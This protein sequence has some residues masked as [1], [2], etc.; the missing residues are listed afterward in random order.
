MASR[1]PGSRRRKPVAAL[2]ASIADATLALRRKRSRDRRRGWRRA[3]VTALGVLVVAAL[4]WTIGFSPWLAAKDV[5]VEGNRVLTVA[6]VEGRAAVP[7]GTPLARLRTAEIADRVATLPAVADVEVHRSWPGRVVVRVSERTPVVQ[8]QEG[9]AFRWAD[10]EGVVFHQTNKA[11]PGLVTVQA[12]ADQRILA[13][14]ATVTSSLTDP[15]RARVLRITAT[16]PDT[17]TLVL[18]KGQTVVWGSA[19]ESTTKAQ[20]ATAM[21]GVKATVF[22]VSAPA[23]P[24]SR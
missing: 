7:M 22:D 15:L 21:L 8:L 2:P 14:L 6:E 3:L 1:Q 19:A 18:D 12:P 5:T 4:V 9:G 24:T 17:I 16:G 10:A 13:D 23:S 11:D 20:V